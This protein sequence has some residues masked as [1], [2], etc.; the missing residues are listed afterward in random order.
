MF[1]PRATAAP[2]TGKPE[3]AATTLG[4]MLMRYH[5]G[6]YLWSG[7]AT[8]LDVGPYSY[9][10]QAEGGTKTVSVTHLTLDQEVDD[11]LRRQGQRWMKQQTGNGQILPLGW[12]MAGAPKFPNNWYGADNTPRRGE[13]GEP[14]TRIYK[15]KTAVG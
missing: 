6:S 8:P 10:E 15:E 3:K 2:K 14:G 1:V 9:T 5:S 11:L 4:V 12:F 7:G 13:Y